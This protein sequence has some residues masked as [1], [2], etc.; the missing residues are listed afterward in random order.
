MKYSSCSNKVA[1]WHAWHGSSGLFHP[2]GL[3]PPWHGRLSERLLVT[4][5]RP[6]ILIDPVARLQPCPKGVPAPVKGVRLPLAPKWSL[7]SPGFHES[8]S[9]K[10][11]HAHPWPSG[12]RAEP[13]SGIFHSHSGTYFLFPT[14]IRKAENSST[15]N[16]KWPLQESFTFPEIKQSYTLLLGLH[17]TCVSTVCCIRDYTC[18]H[19]PKLMAVC[20]EFIS[21]SDT[22]LFY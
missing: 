1:I 16:H 17:F 2:L 9:A 8:K 4:G 3:G 5:W 19:V 6:Q 10:A 11:G 13:S 15:E 21:L 12:S 22:Q 14:K 7:R 20:L 18:L